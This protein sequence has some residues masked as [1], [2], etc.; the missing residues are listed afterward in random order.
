MKFEDE[1]TL[2]LRGICWRACRS[3]RRAWCT[4]LGC[5]PGNSAELLSRRFPQAVDHRYRHLRGYAGPRAGA[6]SSRRGSSGRTSPTG[7]PTRRRISFSPTPRCTFV[8]DHHKLFPRLI[9]ALVPGGVLA[10]QMPSTATESSHALMRMVAAEGPWSSRLAAGRQDPAADRRI[11]GLLR[12][13]ASV[14]GSDRHLD[15]DLYP[16]P[17]GSRQHR[18]L[19]RRLGPPAISGEKLADDERCAFL[20]RYREGS[21]RRLSRAV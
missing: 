2:A 14:R 6:R 16:C 7:R 20:A 19:V 5:G 12:G 8:P 13:A 11:R 3:R 18:G 1:R 9:Q 17:S 10:A 4:T 15:D 21:R